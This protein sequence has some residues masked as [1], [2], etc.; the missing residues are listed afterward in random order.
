MENT[1]PA[2]ATRRGQGIW[3]GVVGAATLALTV[4]CAVEAGQAD[5]LLLGVVTAAAIPGVLALSQLLL[6]RGGRIEPATVGVAGL[7]AAIIGV[8]STGEDNG[9]M[10]LGLLLALLAAVPF[11][12]LSGFL[13]LHARTGHALFSAVAVLIG[14]DQLVTDI[15]PE[16]TANVRAPLLNSLASN[17]LRIPGVALV[18][19]AL[20]LV[21]AWYLPRQEARLAAREQTWSRVTVHLF[22]PSFLL[23]TVVGLLYTAQIGAT[24]QGELGKTFMI[25]CLLALTAG[26]CS[27]R[28]GEGTVG[29]VAVGSLFAGALQSFLNFE[30]VSASPQ[31]TILCGTAV[32]FL[33]LDLARLSRPAPTT[34]PEPVEIPLP[35]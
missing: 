11:A 25:S 2:T 31:S 26:G 18:A 23:A 19:A 13:S 7:G 28:T 10:F 6:L 9:A 14:A 16:Q 1:A 34:A 22:L 30:G 27:L 29:D 17:D 15:A 35:R 33:L 21:T 5:G 32:A 24:V 8:N 20:F 12:F 3:R 4:A